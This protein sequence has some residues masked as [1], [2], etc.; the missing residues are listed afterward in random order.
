MRNR[1]T[2]PRIQ[3][4]V[5]LFQNLRVR[6]HVETTI[7]AYFAEDEVDEQS[8]DEMIDTELTLD[9]IGVSSNPI[10]PLLLEEA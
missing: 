8:D 6:D 1:L 2:N 9:E 7:P 5:Y 4:L 10:D 3:K